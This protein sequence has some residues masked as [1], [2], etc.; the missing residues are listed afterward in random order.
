VPRSLQRGGGGL[1][2]DG[3]RRRVDMARARWL[4]EEF[5]E[6]QIGRAFGDDDGDDDDL[7]EWDDDDEDDWEDDDDWDDDEEDEDEDDED[8]EDDG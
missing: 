5:R 6:D 8:W 4:D 1:G 3:L 7:D 2:G